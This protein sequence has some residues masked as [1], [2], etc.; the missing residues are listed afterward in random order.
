MRERKETVTLKATAWELERWHNAAYRVKRDVPR[1]LI[2]A[3]DATARYLRELDR[4]RRPDFVMI[5]ETE[6]RKLGALLKAAREAVEHL[7]K[8]HHSPIYG[9]RP[10]QRNLRD[11]VEEID[12]FLIGRG[13]EYPCD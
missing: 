4:Q 3:G 9:P 2:F 12:R 7:P 13:E 5:R 10:I 8:V 6:K 11:A 1:F